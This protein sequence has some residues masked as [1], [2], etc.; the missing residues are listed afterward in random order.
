MALRSRPKAR[1][2]SV[3]IDDYFNQEDDEDNTL[4]TSMNGS[5]RDMTLC[6]CGHNSRKSR[7]DAML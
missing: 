7:K 5:D 4:F 3:L 6:S 1:A 2:V